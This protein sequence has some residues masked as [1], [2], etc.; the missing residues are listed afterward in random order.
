MMIL[1][2]SDKYL[3]YMF[4]KFFAP[5]CPLVIVY[6]NLNVKK[7]IFFLE[8]NRFLIKFYIEFDHFWI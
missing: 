8:K 6:N 4:P 1:D 5:N 3:L 2:F 7:A